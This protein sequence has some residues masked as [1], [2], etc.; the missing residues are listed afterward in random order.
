MRSIRKTVKVRF[1]FLIVQINLSKSFKSSPCANFER[2]CDREKLN[3]IYEVLIIGSNSEYK[4]IQT[5]LY[6][7]ET[8]ESHFN[9]FLIKINNSEWRWM[10][11][12]VRQ[13][14]EAHKLFQLRSKLN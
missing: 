7:T 14:C 8:L 4:F 13:R 3:V 5:I 10:N 6:K 11:H 2:Q 9:A 12:L 1:M